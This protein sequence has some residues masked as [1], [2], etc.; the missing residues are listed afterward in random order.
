MQLPG[1]LYASVLR[2]PHAHAHLRGIDSTGV[3][4]L[5]DVVAVL[6]GDDIAHVLPDIPTRAMAGE[7][8]VEEMRAPGQPVLA[9]G[10]VCYVGQ[11]VAVVVAHDRYTARDAVDRMQVDYAPLPALLD[12]LAAAQADSTPIHAQVGTNIALRI[13]HDRQGGSRK[14]KAHFSPRVTWL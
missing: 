2:S 13:T 5:P 9:R 1:M 14:N 7:W 12:P 4:R 3:R 10:K 8:Q 11:P 6:T